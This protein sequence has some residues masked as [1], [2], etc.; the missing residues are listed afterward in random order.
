MSLPKRIEITEVGPRDGWQNHKAMI[1]PTEVK[2]KYVKK[3]R[4]IR[5]NVI[6]PVYVGVR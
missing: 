3:M 1:I 4:K 5:E 2:A 6:V